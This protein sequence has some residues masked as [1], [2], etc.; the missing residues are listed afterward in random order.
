MPTSLEFE[1]YAEVAEKLFGNRLT[2]DE[3]KTVFEDY[4]IHIVKNEEVTKA[5]MVESFLS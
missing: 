5:I 1:E 2:Q 4:S 3:I